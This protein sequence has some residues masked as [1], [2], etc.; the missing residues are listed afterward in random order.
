M[1]EDWL[2]LS[3]KEKEEKEDKKD[4]KKPYS[5]D[6]KLM[7]SRTITI[8]GGID[9]KLAKDVCQ[10]LLALATESDEPIKLYLHSQ[11]GHVES[12]D[13]IFD[14]IRFIKPEVKI[15]GTGW[16]ASA[17]ALIFAAADKKNRFCMPNTRFLLHQPSGGV[18]GQA[19]DIGIEAREIVKMRRR[20]N[21]IFADATG[22]P[23]E[24]IEKQTDRN[25][26][27]TADEAVKYGLVTK[28]V[29]SA[30][31]VK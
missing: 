21:E 14:M 22:Q 8:Y 6:Q 4:E 26:W 13:S 5:V 7:E 27:M 2:E 15:V 3:P 20:L 18:M 17:G 31:E 30:D 11:G 25:F 23:I 10:R 29:K 1:N 28:I 19:T 16:V 12:G 24:Q 9:Q